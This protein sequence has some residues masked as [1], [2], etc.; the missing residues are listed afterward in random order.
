MGTPHGN[1]I[2]ET[3]YSMLYDEEFILL[4]DFTLIKDNLFHTFSVTFAIWDNFLGHNYLQKALIMQKR[5]IRV[6]LGLR[7]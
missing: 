2:E 3:A 6:M 1:T 4:S 7:Q 5:I